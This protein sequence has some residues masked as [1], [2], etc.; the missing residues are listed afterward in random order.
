MESVTDSGALIVTGADQR[1]WRCLWQF[2]GNVEHKGLF[3]RSH[4]VAFDLGLETTTLARLQARYPWCEFRRFAFDEYPAHVAMAAGS[5][6]L[7]PLIIS[8]LM[9]ETYGLLFWFDSATLIRTSDLSFL[10]AIIKRNGIYVLRGQTPL[11]RRCDP[12]ALAR[13]RVPFFIRRK[14][15]LAAGAL[16]FNSNEPKIRALVREWA[17]HALIKEHIAP[18]IPRLPFHR[19]EQ[20]LLTWLVYQGEDSGILRL[21]GEEI[22]I[23]SCA[24]VRWMSSRNFIPSGAPLWASALYRLCYAVYKTV[25]QMLWRLIHL[26]GSRLNGLHRRIKEHF[27]VLVHDGAGNVRRLRPPS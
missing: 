19:P 9:E 23:S 3:C 27:S 21:T 6:A 13:F 8:Q 26:R 20:A 22:D 12:D 17:A 11:E 25:D 24:P 1:Y 5:S 16:G 10:E 18:R 15:E 2:L 4:F 7:K 14:P